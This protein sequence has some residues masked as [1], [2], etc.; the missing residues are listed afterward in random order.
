M[1]FLKNLFKPK[2]ATIKTYSDFWKWFCDNERLFFKVIKENGDVE[3][4][5]FNKLS[6]KLD[7]LKEGFWYQVGM[8]DDTTAEL[9]IT[10]DGEIKNIVFVEELIA[11]APKIK[12]WKFTA[13]KPPLD[14]KDVAIEMAGYKFD[15]DNIHFCI[16]MHSNYP[17]EIDISVVHDSCTEDNKSEVGRG[18]YIFLENY[19]GE[20]DFAMA[21][22]NLKIETRSKIVQELIPIEKLR[23]YLKWRQSEFIEKY[24]G[25]R[26]D[27]ESDEHSIMEAFHEDGSPLIAVINTH[28]LKWDSKAS[29][30]WILA[31]EIP[32]KEGTN[33]GMPDNITYSQLDE[34]DKEI[35]SELK[36]IDGY[37]YIG[38]QTAKNVREINFACIDFRKPSL[39]SY[40]IQKKY[41]KQFAISYNI[42][43]DKYWQS[44][45]R[46]N[47]DI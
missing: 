3:K 10:A 14:I 32:Y 13:L 6:P 5:I 36:D 22:D 44:F 26:H 47:P 34:I 7:E 16:N 29:H 45:D 30:P 15:C 39:V 33:N 24:E 4:Q 35:I 28:L 43:K 40:K 37:L 18:I 46:F 1:D 19:L 27:T 42:Y 2:E 17:D 20:I 25:K 31:I 23:D 8:Y 9:I 38:R 41:E 21:I 11:T 12:N